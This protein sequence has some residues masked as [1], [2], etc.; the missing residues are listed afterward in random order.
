VPA[1][2]TDHRTHRVRRRLG[3]RFRLERAAKEHAADMIRR[4]SFAHTS[5]EGTTMV[6]GVPVEAVAD[7]WRATDAAEPGV[8]S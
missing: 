3:R 7:P 1:H 6:F 4:R 2:I 5:P 8:R